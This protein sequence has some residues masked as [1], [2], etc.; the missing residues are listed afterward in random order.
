MARG[1]EIDIAVLVSLPAKAFVADSAATEQTNRPQRT[2]VIPV[3]ENTRLKKLL[4]E[5][6]R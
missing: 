4:E 2:E 1:A 3:M 5:A 6:V